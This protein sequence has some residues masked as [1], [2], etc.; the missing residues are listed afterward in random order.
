MKKLKLIQIVILVAIL[1]LTSG[2][3]W[4]IQSTGKVYS[5]VNNS[6]NLYIEHETKVTET[7]LALNAHLGYGGMIH[8][9]KNYVIRGDSKYLELFKHDVSHIHL[10]IKTLELLG[11]SSQE[12]K[13]LDSLGLLKAI[14]LT[15]DDYEE[16]LEVAFSMY[17][18]EELLADID[19][20]VK[21][22]DKQ[23]L[24]AL[25]ALREQIVKRSNL[26]QKATSLSFSKANQL[27]SRGQIFAIPLIILTALLIYYIRQIRKSNDGAVRAQ[28]W[29]DTLLDTAPEAT[30]CSN[31]SGEIIRVNNEAVSL[32]GYTSQE[33]L[34]MK[35]EALIPRRFSTPHPKLRDSYFKHPKTRKMSDKTE[36]FA[37]KKNGDEIE[38]SIN[39]SMAGNDEDKVAIATIRDVTDAHKTTRELAYQAT[40]DGLTGLMNRA[41]FEVQLKQ[42]V[43]LAKRTKQQSVL[44][45]LDLDQFKIVNDTSGHAAGDE[46]LKQISQVFTSHLRETDILA[47][48]G[49]DEFAVLMINCDLSDAV[50]KAESLIALV[51]DFHFPW[52]DQHFTIGVSIGISLIDKNTATEQDVLKY[53]DIACYAAK[54]AGRSRVHVYRESDEKLM[55]QHSELLWVARINDALEQDKF[56]LYVQEISPTDSSLEHV[57]YEVLIRLND[58]GTIIPPGAFLPS[59]ERYGLISKID[60]WVINETFEWVA[61]HADSLHKDTHFSLNLSGRSMGDSHVLE[62]IESWLSSGKVCPSRI[63][64]EVTETMAIANLHDANN[65]IKAIKEHG[66]GFSL[67]DFGSGLSSFGYLKNLNVDTLKIDGL[68]VRDILDDPIDAAMVESINNI[69]HVMGMKTIAE[70][71]ENDAIAEKL[72]LLGVD[73]LQGYG[74]HKPAPIDHLLLKG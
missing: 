1:F 35:V 46:L 10:N 21:V 56:C 72:R 41:E 37:L 8:N 40:H 43:L 48:L 19:D 28:K 50:E 39:L 25:E 26:I 70:F 4:F 73:F 55:L 11:A 23:A 14:K 27:L 64:F 66:C 51:S 62:Q 57:N 63:H 34:T 71:V 59:A 33:L 52:E 36:L 54:D 30:I 60:Y 12:V 29:V 2:W 15:V 24:K 6:W 53:A 68:F 65:F 7:L 16:Q 5:Q 69:G 32:F 61:R 45:F 49:G 67:D 42:T 58:D 22:D 9:F 3:L 47:R 74:I 20:T 38:V 44:C 17:Q 13:N 18:T 31:S